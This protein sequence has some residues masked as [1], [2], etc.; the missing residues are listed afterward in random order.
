M[1]GALFSVDVER[2]AEYLHATEGWTGQGL[3][4]P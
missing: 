2:D 4:G 1:I 3:S